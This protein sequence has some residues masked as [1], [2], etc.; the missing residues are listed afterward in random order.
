MNVLLRATALAS[1]AILSLPAFA[2]SCPT[3]T[4]AVSSA[5]LL[6]RDKTMCAARGG[7][8]WQE[9]HAAGG[10]LVDYKMGPGDAVD[11]TETV[12]TWSGNGGLLTHAYTGG[13]SFVWAMCR[14]GGPSTQTFTLVST[15]AGS[16]TGVS[17]Q[18]GQ[19]RCP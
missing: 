4:S 15:S 18:S 14:E 17:L 5:A 10:S 1:I 6:V 16:I 19:V 2:Q 12:G 7:D 11:P 8:R 3:G 13:G 9:F